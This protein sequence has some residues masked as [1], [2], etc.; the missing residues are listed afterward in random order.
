MAEG[1]SGRLVT[2][3]RAGRPHG[4]DG[5]IRVLEPEHGL[6]VGTEV[7]IAGRVRPVRRRRGTD[8]QPIVTL[9]G[10]GDREA[11]LELGGELLLVAEG[12]LPLGTGEWL[13]E[14][15]VGCDVP[16]LGPVRR[17]LAGPSCD[18]LELDDGTLVPLV[19]DAVLDVDLARRTVS[20]DREFLGLGG[21]EA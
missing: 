13:A 17:I 18:V 16:G 8:L 14:D 9:D 6:G 7:T 5:S 19:A 10:I 11:A 12:E 2:A 15:L 4:L 20:V 3:G 1:G 21:P